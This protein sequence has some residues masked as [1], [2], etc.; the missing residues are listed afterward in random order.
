MDFFEGIFA[1]GVAGFK[2]LG[3]QIEAFKELSPAKIHAFGVG[4]VLLV[5]VVDGYRIGIG[6]ERSIRSAH[7]RTQIYPKW[8]RYKNRAAK[9]LK[10]G[11]DCG[12]GGLCHRPNLGQ[13]PHQNAAKQE[14]IEPIQ[15]T[16]MTG[17]KFATVFDAFFAFEGAFEEVSGCAKY[18]HE[19][20]EDGALPD[21]GDLKEGVKTVGA[22]GC[23]EQGA[24][25]ESFPG[26]LG[27]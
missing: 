10:G 19:C 15:S 20:S 2:F 23:G 26:F 1:D 5:K 21:V 9:C 25:D 4:L 27:R 11:G 3:S 14:G 24:T 16:A 6:Q 17:Q 8:V 7:N 12:G 22:N 13:C 18:T